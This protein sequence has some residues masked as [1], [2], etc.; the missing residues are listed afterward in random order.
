MGLGVAGFAATHVGR[1][2]R[3]VV[4]KLANPDEGPSRTGFAPVVKKVLPA[5]VSVESTKVSKIPT[6]FEGGMPDDP[7]SASSSATVR[8]GSSGR[9]ASAGTARARARFGRHHDPG[10][11]HPDQ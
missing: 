2:I 9:R 11:L 5:V 4:L 3:R 7:C 6:G 1:A 8:T 10:R